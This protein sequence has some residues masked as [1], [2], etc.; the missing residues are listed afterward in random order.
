MNQANA[1]P[2]PTATAASAVGEHLST[3]P[4]LTRIPLLRQ[5]IQKERASLQSSLSARAKEQVDSVRE[6][7]QG[8]REAR[9]SI[10]GIKECMKEVEQSMSDPRGNI[11]GFGKLVEVSV[12]HRRFA[13]ALEMVDSLRGM[14]DRLTYI[15]TLLAED[16]KDPLGSSPNL[17]QIHYHLTELETFRNETL[18]Q[19]KRGK[20][21]IATRNTL[22]A[23][24]EKLGEM[25]EA[26]EAH[27]FR[28]ARELVELARNGNASVAVKIAKIAEVEG[29]RDQKAIAI[30][31]VKKSG[32]LEVA[33]RF[34]SLQAEARTIKHYR[35]KVMDA[36]RDSCMTAVEKSYQRHGDDGVAWM[37]DLDWIFDDLAVVEKELTP[38]FPED[39]NVS[40]FP[41]FLTFPLP[42]AYSILPDRLELFSSFFPLLHSPVFPDSDLF[43]L[44]FVFR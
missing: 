17:F 20:S 10:E 37:D 36:I 19:A 18:A 29:S 11:E 23:Y 4:T 32:N 41:S 9:N 8:L 39:W 27:Y 43:L 1:Q 34:K 2:P 25:M 6:G 28:L 7:L 13:Q 15:G 42:I 12:V 21:S 38:M 16:R 24:F 44:Y 5:R 30:K 35:A 22:E 40:I 26:F 3:P 14:T 31:M 33:A